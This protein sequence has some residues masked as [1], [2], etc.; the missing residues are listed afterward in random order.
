VATL[1]WLLIV[2]FVGNG[3]VGALAY[4]FFYYES[5]SSGHLDRVRERFGSPLRAMVRAWAKSF[6]WM[7]VILACSVLYYLRLLRPS[8]WK[9][10]TVG[11]PI[12]L[13]HGLYHN[14][15]AWL[16]FMRRFR[17]AGYRDLR[18]FSYNSWSGDPEELASLLAS[19]IEDAWRE[20]GRPAALVG[21]SLGGALIRG[22]L[23]KPELKGK[24]AAVATLGTPVEGSKL[25]ALGPGPLAGKILYRSKEVE[26]LC[27]AQAFEVPSLALVSDLDDMV[28][29]ADSLFAG[30]YPGWRVEHA[31]PVSHITMLYDAGCFRSVLAFLVEHRVEK[32]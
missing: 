21:H 14:E 25:A 3:F 17:A 10:R 22:C 13:V 2:L 30:R 6:G 16:S 5:A 8:R 1:V 27:S 19:R 11:A 18:P 23:R 9:R 24:I 7:A 29:P 31:P 4:A 32:A 12:I 15:T 28:L 20:T 26:T